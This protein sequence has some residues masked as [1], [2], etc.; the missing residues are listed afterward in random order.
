YLEHRQ[1]LEGFK[2][3]DSL[4]NIVTYRD[5]SKN[6][7]TKTCF[8]RYTSLDNNILTF[9]R[10]DGKDVWIEN[11]EFA[12]PKYMPRTVFGTI[13]N[14]LYLESLKDSRRGLVLVPLQKI[15]LGKVH[16]V[17]AAGRLQIENITPL[18]PQSSSTI[19]TERLGNQK[20]VTYQMHNGQI[21]PTSTESKLF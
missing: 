10:I 19:A 15:D 14:F 3:F 18:L 6:S 11:R 5:Q 21:Q 9:L 7:I 16:T 1:D 12:I 17:I 20:Y 2:R 4:N 8:P 13:E